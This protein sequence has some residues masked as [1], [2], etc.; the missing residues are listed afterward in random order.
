MELQQLEKKKKMEVKKN[1]NK[2]QKLPPPSK[3]LNPNWAQLQQKLNSQP[4]S[5][6]PTRPSEHLV[7]GKRKERPDEKQSEDPQPSPLV[8]A[9]DDSR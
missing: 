9:N 7:L 4:S 3:P 2:K 6:P 8:P 1:P 5:K